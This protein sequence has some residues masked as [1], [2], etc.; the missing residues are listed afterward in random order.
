[1][2][3]HFVLRKVVSQRE[4]REHSKANNEEDQEDA[5]VGWVEWA[6][7]LVLLEYQRAAG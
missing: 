2:S 3:E 1:M 7:R 5:E 4:Q 6:E